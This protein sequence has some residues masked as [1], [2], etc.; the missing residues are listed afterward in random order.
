MTRQVFLFVPIVI[1]LPLFLGLDGVWMSITI[2]D[3][4]IVAITGI[5]LVRVFR[6][7]G[8]PESEPAADDG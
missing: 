8:A 7:L 6:S 3:A 2:A 4:T 1:V 5:I